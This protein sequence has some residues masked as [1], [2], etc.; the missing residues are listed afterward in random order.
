MRYAILLLVCVGAILGCEGVQTK[1]ERKVVRAG[2]SSAPP[3][4]QESKGCCCRSAAECSADG[5]A[6]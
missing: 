4:R 6:K 5:C 2:P 3:A 1:P